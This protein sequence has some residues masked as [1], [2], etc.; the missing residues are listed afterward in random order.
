MTFG[1]HAFTPDWVT[2]DGDKAPGWYRSGQNQWPGVALGNGTFYMSTAPAGHMVNYPPAAVKWT[3]PR[4]T[5]VSIQGA[6]WN[7]RGAT[8]LAI[9]VNGS[10]RLNVWLNGRTFSNPYTFNLP[11][12]AVAPGD[13]I[14]LLNGPTGDYM[15]FD[16]TIQ[17]STSGTLAGTVTS[18]WDNHPVQGAQV[19]LPEPF[20]PQPSH[21]IRIQQ[22]LHQSTRSANGP[23]RDRE[24]HRHL[25]AHQCGDARCSHDYHPAQA[26]AAA[27]G[28]KDTSGQVTPSVTH[29]Y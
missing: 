7:L 20:L 8:T 5:T 25:P 18:S 6:A 3:A 22:R 17:E 2:R 1:L 15:G 10:K 29:S 12:I 9:A 21:G 24:R 26:G 13:T 27:Q 4:A 11:N 28:A 23:L 16:L 14:M 19:T